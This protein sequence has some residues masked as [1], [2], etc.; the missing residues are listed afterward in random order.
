MALENEFDLDSGN[1]I[2]RKY[3][4]D[5]VN[6]YNKLLEE[7]STINNEL[8]ILKENESVKRYLELCKAREDNYSKNNEVY[9][10]ILRK[11]Y[12]TCNHVL[13]ESY[14]KNYGDY[15]GRSYHY[16]G[17]IKCGL[18]ESVLDSEYDCFTIEE[19]VMKELMSDTYFD[20]I[21]GIRTGIS[22]DLSKSRYLYEEIKN[23]NPGLSEE[24]LIEIFKS[25]V[26]EEKGAKNLTYKMI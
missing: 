18:D 5:L 14:Y 9:K 13:V 1:V 4:K 19:K 6:Q 25:R 26:L 10:K 21:N 23:N 16:Y 20:Y 22:Y 15:E 24:A 11:R 2:D 7:G 12:Q 8:N 17:C 3:M